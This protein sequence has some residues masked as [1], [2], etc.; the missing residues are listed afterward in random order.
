MLLNLAICWKFLLILKGQS[1]GNQ[2]NIGSSET[3]CKTFKWINSPIIIEI[4]WI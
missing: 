1:A 3:I 2:S 4:L